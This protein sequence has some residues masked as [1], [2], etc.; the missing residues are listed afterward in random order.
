VTDHHD[1]WPGTLDV[2]TLLASGFRPRPF[3]QFVLK[4]T[5]R[6]DLACDYCY[7]FELADQGWRGKP[8]RMSRDVLQSAASRIAEHAERHELPAVDVILH[9][10]EPLLYG[11]DGLAE[12]STTIRRALP[13]E[14]AVGLR[15]Q[16]NGLRLDDAMLRVLDDHQVRIGVSLDGGRADHDRHRRTPDGRGSWSDVRA[17]VRRLAEGYPQR[18]AGLL[19]VVD[20]SNDPVETYQALLE[21]R[22]PLVELL[23]PLATWATPPPGVADPGDPRRATPYGDWL[24]ALFDRWY[25]VAARETGIRFLEELVQLV[26]GGSSRVETLGLSPSGVVV[27]DTDGAIE[28][29][30]TLRVAYQGAAAAGLDVRRNSLDEA[31]VHPGIVARQLGARALCTQC[32]ACPLH[33]VCGAGYYPHRYRPGTGFLN[34]SVYCH[35]L[36]RLIRH[37]S[38]RVDDDVRRL[39]AQAASVAVA[40]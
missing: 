17:G 38:R 33:R 12:A 10:G 4:L 28:Q 29:V 3:R 6:C 39:A 34:P 2:P 27:L 31:L 11:A 21:L 18:Y 9:G 14:V 16:T 20:P 23:L 40:P 19:C 26:L 5:A 32:R 37:V 15:L 13:A 30:D 24:V 7:M 35:D 36:Q 25:P 1:E 8:A 22:P